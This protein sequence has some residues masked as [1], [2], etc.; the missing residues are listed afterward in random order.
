MRQDRP[1]GAQRPSTINESL[2]LG[3]DLTSLGWQGRS[4][5]RSQTNS[6]LGRDPA[7]WHTHVANFI[8][9]R[10]AD[11]VPGLDVVIDG[12]KS[13]PE[14]DLRV[15]P[16]VEVS[17]IRLRLSAHNSGWSL[18]SNGDLIAWFSASEFRMPKPVA[19]E[20]MPGSGDRESNSARFLL[21]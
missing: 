18:E 13:G 2:E 11:L 16:H 5:L 3:D 20:S 19:Y 6:S 7:N 21:R 1:R 14:Y 8:A 4:L 12:G 9:V 17:S 10:A 15:A